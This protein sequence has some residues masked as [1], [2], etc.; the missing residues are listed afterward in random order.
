MNSKKQLKISGFIIAIAI[1]LILCIIFLLAVQVPFLQKKDTYEASHA[2]AVSQINYY[3]SYLDNVRVDHA[4]EILLG[5]K[6]QVYKVAEMVGYKNVDYFHI[7]FKKNTGI[8]PAEYRKQNGSDEPAGPKTNQRT[9]ESADEG[10]NDTQN[11]ECPN[12]LVRQ[13]HQLGCEVAGDKTD[14]QLD[15]QT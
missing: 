1:I 11:Q 9:E 4:K 12:A 8:S 10:T 2:S 15:N 13:I 7:K 3:N 6:I 5:T 14:N